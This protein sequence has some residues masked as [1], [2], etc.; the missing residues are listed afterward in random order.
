M[1]RLCAEV[2]C[3]VFTGHQENSNFCSVNVNV[4]PGDCEWFC[5]TNDYWTVIADMC[6]EYVTLYSLII[7]IVSK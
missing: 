1:L 4:G 7:I 2:N 3:T 5:V 6:A